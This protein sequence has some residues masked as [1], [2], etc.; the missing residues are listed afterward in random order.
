MTE[1]SRLWKAAA[2]I[3][4]TCGMIVS[5]CGN[6]QSKSV[7]QPAVY[8]VADMDVLIKS[9]PKY[10]EYFKDVS[11]NLSQSTNKDTS[12]DKSGEKK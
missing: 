1:R 11:D 2:M 7:E 3:L 5:G 10:T 8:G 9:H 12:S 6:N 4:L